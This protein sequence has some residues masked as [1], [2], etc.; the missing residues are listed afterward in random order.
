M[1]DRGDEAAQFLMGQAIVAKQGDGILCQL[2]VCAVDI[3]VRCTLQHAAVDGRPFKAGLQELAVV[4]VSNIEG[5]LNP[6]G[7]GNAAE[8]GG[9]LPVQ[10]QRLRKMLLRQGGA[11]GAD[12]P[13][14]QVGVLLGLIRIH[15]EAAGEQ[16]LCLFQIAVVHRDPT[17]QTQRR[18]IAR[19]LLQNFAKIRS[20]FT[21]RLQAL[22]QR[23][24]AV[25]LAIG[26][27]GL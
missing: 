3:K 9:R 5:T 24:R 15:V 21:P 23:D 10:F 11:L 26:Q 8:S 7:M 17:Q 12:R 1:D 13:V 20:A 19:I 22:N 18:S 6:F 14:T 16:E 2:R 4:Q 25:G 27:I